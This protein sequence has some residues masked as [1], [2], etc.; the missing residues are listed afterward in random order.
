MLPFFSPKIR[1]FIDES[2]TP[3]SYDK[4]KH[5][6]HDKYF[7][8]AAVIITPNEYK[9][10]KKGIL[11]ISEKYVQY[12][13]GKEIK[14]NHI[15]C[16]NPLYIKDGGKA[17][18]TFYLDKE[19]GQEKYNEFCTDIKDLILLTDFKIISTTT[20]KEVA[21]IRYSSLNLH[22]VLLNDLWE[23]VSIYYHL[24]K[25]KPKMRIMFDA[26]KGD[27]DKILRESY[28]RF[29]TSGS[30]YFE[31]DRLNDLNL[32]KDV[33]PHDSEECIGIQLA[34][35]CAY[36]I[37]KQIETRSHKFFTDVVNKKLHGNVQDVKTRKRINMG[38][39]ISLN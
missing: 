2:G 19:I 29:K 27:A 17:V 26:T 30:W 22:H 13:N 6:V 21:G 14:S 38:T 31:G 4:N 37:K 9:K 23:R 12:L 36:P 20:N 11:D 28:A 33:W 15:R 39:K 1:I 35:L 34:D 24:Q 16:S 7:T 25:T 10:Y 3:D 5:Q 32:D 8:L 18:F